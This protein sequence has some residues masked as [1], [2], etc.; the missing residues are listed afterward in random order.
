MS[1][2]LID[3]VSNVNRMLN[4]NTIFLDDIMRTIDKEGIK[5]AITKIE[6]RIE[7]LLEQMNNNIDY[8]SYSFKELQET[9]EN[10]EIIKLK[11]LKNLINE[12]IDH[13]NL[14]YEALTLE[15]K[16]ELIS[17][18]SALIKYTDNTISQIQKIENLIENKNKLNNLISITKENDKLKKEILEKT[19]ELNEK[20]IIKKIAVKNFL[21]EISNT[22][23]KKVSYESSET[24]Q[25]EHPKPNYTTT[26]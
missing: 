4:E 20:G 2:F 21:N 22:V 26:K 17:F 11:N 25:I 14:F 23:E 5:S 24:Y 15:E 13:D 3:S 16:E 12:V 9:K 18:L 8:Q 7:E 1:E 10:N 19:N 6:N